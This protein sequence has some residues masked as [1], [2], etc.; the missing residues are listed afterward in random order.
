[1]KRSLLW[2]IDKTARLRPFVIIGGVFIAVGIA[3]LA[4]PIRDLVS[5]GGFPFWLLGI[6]LI[7]VGAWYET[8]V[9][10]ALRVRREGE[11]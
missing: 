6:V 11:K 9:V 1:V 4:L 3:V 2:D 5:V 7:V 10:H 8:A